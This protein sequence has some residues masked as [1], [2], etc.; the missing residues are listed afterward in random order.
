MTDLITARPIAF[1]R[2]QT[3]GFKVPKLGFGAAIEALSKAF[4]QALYLAYVA[5]YSAGRGQPTN[6]VSE[7]SDGRDPR[8]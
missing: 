1:R 8:W 7:D 2:F 4:G 5:P 6:A 3:T